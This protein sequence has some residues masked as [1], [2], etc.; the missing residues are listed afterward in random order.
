MRRIP[1][2]RS[3]PVP[4][5]QHSGS[6]RCRSC[7]AP[8]FRQLI[9]VIV[10]LALS[11]RGCTLPRCGGHLEEPRMR[12]GARRGGVFREAG[13]R[14]A[15]L[16]TREDC[17]WPRGRRTGRA[18]SRRMPFLA[19]GVSAAETRKRNASRAPESVPP[20]E[21]AQW[22]EPY[23][24]MPPRLRGLVAAKNAR[25]QCP[26]FADIGCWKTR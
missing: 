12:G 13:T 7:Q 4:N 21:L 20:A 15:R 16:L 5:C 10:F 19:E 11:S 23:V 9:L 18:P 14:G 24:G 22:S 6:V 1:N 2:P 26:N 25:A 3:C 8:D 17:C